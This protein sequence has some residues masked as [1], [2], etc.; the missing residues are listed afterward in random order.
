[1]AVLFVH[2][3]FW[4]R[5]PGCPKATTP[6]SNT[7]FWLNKFERNEDRD[8]EVRSE[9]LALGWRVGVV[10]ECETKPVE[11]PDLVRAIGQWLAGSENEF[12]F[13][14]SEPDIAPNG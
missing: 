6:S 1:M 5:H 13:T 12:E 7:Q 14:Q 2:G 8:K 10:W 4:H 11:M 3:C 9:L